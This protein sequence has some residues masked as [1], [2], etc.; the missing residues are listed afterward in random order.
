MIS[1]TEVVL[2]IRERCPVFGPE[3]KRRV[4]GTVEF[5]EA[6]ADET[7]DLPV[8][9]CF[10]IPLDEVDINGLMLNTTGVQDIRDFFATIVAVD[11]SKNRGGAAGIASLEPFDVLKLAREQLRDAFAG[12]RPVQNFNPVQFSRGGTL[13]MDKVRLWHQF[14]WF[15]SY[16]DNPAANPTQDAEIDA[17]L[18]D[19]DVVPA[20][21]PEDFV[22]KLR[23]IYINYGMPERAEVIPSLDDFWKREA[24]PP[25]ATPVQID[26]AIAGAEHV[27]ISGPDA[28][29]VVPTPTAEEFEDAV[30]KAPPPPDTD[31]HGIEVQ[32]PPEDV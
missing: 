15:V 11:N 2:R 31:R 7:A 25:R 4:G 6:F 32:S 24:N 14:E 28:E 20:S 12:W 10:V 23:A 1:L 17:Y 22:H 3:G 29:A 19:M 27:I 30:S 18:N 16:T 8:P 26:A 5:S 9:H 13:G 21:G